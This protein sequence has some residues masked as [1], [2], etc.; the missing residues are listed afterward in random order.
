MIQAAQAQGISGKVTFDPSGE[1]AV[2]IAL[3]PSEAIVTSLFDAIPHR[4]YTRS[5]YDGK[6]LSAE[7]IKLL[8]VAG[9]GD[10][11]RVMLLTKRAEM[12]TVLDYVVQGNTAQF[13]NPAFMKELKSWIRFNDQEATRTGDGLSGRTTGNPSIP[14]WIGNLL[15]KLLFRVQPENDKNTRYIRSSASIAVFVS[16]VDDKAHSFD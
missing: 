5:E 12:D 16:D 10:G 15:S 13:N 4:Q 7:E 8:E 11:V 1:G 14:R 3:E 2:R 9:T 6:P